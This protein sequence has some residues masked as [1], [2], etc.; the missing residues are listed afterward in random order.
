MLGAPLAGSRVAAMLDRWPAG[1]WILGAAAREGLVHRRLRWRGTRE[2]LVVAGDLPIGTGI[3]FGLA[4]PHDGVVRVAETRVGVARPR[5]VRTTHLGLLLS[6]RV[7]AMLCAFFG[8]PDG[9]A[10]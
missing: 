8:A 6:R 10:G 3:L 4:R 9:P 2:L 1:R 5:V 7:A